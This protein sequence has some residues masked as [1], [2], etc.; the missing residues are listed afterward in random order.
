METQQSAGGTQNSQREW[1]KNWWGIIIALIILPIFAVWF[2]WAK[3]KWS[4]VIKVLATIGVVL[5]TVIAAGSNNSSDKNNNQTASSQPPT[6]P[7]ESSSNASAPAEQTAVQTP[8]PAAAPA[9]K[10]MQE[11]ITLDAKADKQSDTFSLQGGKQNV[12]YTLT[13]GSMSM[14]MIYVVKEGESL[15]KDGGFPVVTV[16][17]TGTGD[18]MMR[19]DAGSYYLDV[20]PVNGTCKVVVQEER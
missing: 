15:D 2:I 14:C 6:A 8:T 1:Y 3:T 9:P 12:D 16:D 7:T 17:K 11:V 18:T 10:Q 20:K 13:G 5:I 4:N 19:K